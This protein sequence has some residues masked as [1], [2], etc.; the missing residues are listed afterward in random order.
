M[1]QTPTTVAW[2]QAFQ[3]G[4]LNEA[5]SFFWKPKP[6]EELYDLQS[7]PFQIQNLASQSDL[8]TEKE[9]LREGLK[10]WMI[11]TKD[12]GVIPE[13]LYKE[14]SISVQWNWSEMVSAAFD[15]SPV[16]ENV[17]DM[18]SPNPIVRYWSIQKQLAKCHLDPSAP[19]PESMVQ[20]LDDESVPVQI[21]AAELLLI[22]GNSTTRSEAFERLKKHANADSHGL[23]N[24]VAAMNALANQKMPF[25]KDL[26]KIPVTRTAI[27][28]VYHDYL[29]RLVEYL[30]Q[31]NTP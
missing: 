14:G 25:G 28:P 24:A 18:N 15:A 10:R 8:Q 4:Q 1:F 30:Q 19:V 26:S 22:C 27:E 20:A 21:A 29:K 23:L 9:K 7:D 5:Q 3:R 2:Q 12:H 11:E 13:S 17:P 6:V 31:H 16:E